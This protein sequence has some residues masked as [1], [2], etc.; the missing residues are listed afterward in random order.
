MKR[1]ITI[2]FV[3]FSTNAVAIVNGE[4]VN[5][6][7]NDALVRFDSVRDNIVSNCTGT[8][9]SGKFIITAAHCFNSTK[10]DTAVTNS[11]VI[12]LTPNAEITLHD[13]YQDLGDTSIGMDVAI[14]KMSENFNYENAI[15]FSNLNENPFVY[16]EKI[17]I[18]AFGGTEKPNK[19]TLSLTDWRDCSYCYQ[20]GDY[21]TLNAEMVND[22]HTQGGDSGA[23]WLNKENNIIGIHKGSSW[24]ITNGIKWKNTYSTNLHYAKDFI[25][26]NVNTWNYPT[27]VNL[28]N[29]KTITVQS[30]HQDLMVDEAYT[31]GDLILI[32]EESSCLN[33]VIQPFETCSYTVE[34]TNGELFLNQS[35]VVTFFTSDE[36]SITD[37]ESSTTNSSA[38]GKSGGALNIF[39]LML[40]IPL[41]FTRRKEI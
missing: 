17:K 1:I 15:Y 36:N 33:G 28:K 22:S 3:A 32:P 11:E 5:W 13:T 23:I 2:L 39:Y 30:L 41:L 14:I 4:N 18:N 6:Q 20:A 29:K 27:K 12:S 40:L 37:S 19:A 16:G 26:E 9:I 31:T 7:E 38:S 25:L 35:D 10:I 21:Y 34:G 24:N 8:I